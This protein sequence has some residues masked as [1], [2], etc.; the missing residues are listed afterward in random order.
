MS[1][2]HP[3]APSTFTDATTTFLDPARVVAT[4]LVLFGHA[5]QIF[6]PPQSVTTGGIGVVIF[7]LL[8]GFLITLTTARRWDRPGPQMRNFMIDRVARIF[9][10]FI[11]ILI[12]V[13][14]VN[15]LVGLSLR[16]ILGVNVGPLAFIGNMLLLHDYPVFQFLSHFGPGAHLYPRSYNAAEPFW[17]IPIE[18]WTY[19]VFAFTAFIL[20]RREKP[21]LV[22][23]ALL[24]IGLPVF[25]WNGFAGGAGN[26]SLLWILGS[27]GGILWLNLHLDRQRRMRLGMA[28][29]GFGLLCAGGRL[30]DVGF[31][32]Y[33][34]HLN[35]LTAMIFFGLVMVL[36]GFDRLPGLIA[37]PTAFLAGYSYS[38]YLVHNTVLIV[39]HE[40]FAGVSLE[41]RFVVAMIVA[42]LVAIGAYYLFERHYHA[43]GR[44]LK[45]HLLFADGS[46]AVANDRR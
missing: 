8:S 33:D 34:M 37:R 3:R 10:P 18:F 11:P 46:G 43:V 24:A 17:T 23:M 19:V 41:V 9:T 13:A 26:L 42:H 40:R 25:I 44:Y 7:F 6:Y 4:N 14:F 12:V 27:I 28:I 32:S 16:P 21:G 39:F 15:A 31:K 36:S 30:A 45:E 20:I 35:L 29:I 22:S 2:A 1:D 5:S 38:L